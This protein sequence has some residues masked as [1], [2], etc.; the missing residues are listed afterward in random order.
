MAQRLVR[1]L[2][3][4]CRQPYRPTPEELPDDFPVDKL[5][6]VGTL[7]R[8]VGC[9]ACRQ[10]GYK[11]RVG[12]FEL[13]V[14]TNRIRHLAHERASTWAMTQAALRQGMCTLRQ[15]GWRKVLRGHTTVDE[16]LRVTK[17]N[18]LAVNDA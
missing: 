14:T 1:T 13:L 11:G 9:R 5:R 15:G 2:C 3:H 4:E 7:Y 16:V 18:D 12:L 6:E 10:V 8:A 17:G